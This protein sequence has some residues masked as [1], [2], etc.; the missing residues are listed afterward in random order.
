MMP[1]TGRMAAAKKSRGPL[2]NRLIIVFPPGLRP[3]PSGAPRAGRRNRRREFV[4]LLRLRQGAL[5]KPYPSSRRRVEAG[6]GDDAPP[7]NRQGQPRRL[8][9]LAFA[10]RTPRRPRHDVGDAQRQLPSTYAQLSASH[11]TVVTTPV[12]RWIHISDR[13]APEPDHSEQSRCTKPMILRNT[14]VR[15]LRPT[16]NDELS[17]LIVRFHPPMRCDMRHLEAC[18]GRPL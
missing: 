6:I 5:R 10:D 15:R 16:D 3:A 7:A 17:D 12:S 2:P 11:R 1:I 18:A 4:R 8:R 9:V 13:P 14:H